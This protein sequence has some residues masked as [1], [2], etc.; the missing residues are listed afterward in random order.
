MI[1]LRENQA[2]AA[3]KSTYTEKGEAGGSAAGVDPARRVDI[4]SSA[5]YSQKLHAVR[6]VLCGGVWLQSAREERG[7][8]ENW[9]SKGEGQN[10]VR[11]SREFQETY[12]TVQR[13]TFA[14]MR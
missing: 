8:C 11:V 5:K 6:R 7:I 3:G 9:Q 14:D 1:R 10:W 2:Q 13:D 12:Q 4:N